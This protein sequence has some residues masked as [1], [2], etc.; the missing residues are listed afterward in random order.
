[1]EQMFFYV[2][3]LEVPKNVLI[4]WELKKDPP[5][6]TGY[7]SQRGCDIHTTKNTEITNDIE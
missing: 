6:R 7:P 3:W 5:K 4:N 2:N 1:M